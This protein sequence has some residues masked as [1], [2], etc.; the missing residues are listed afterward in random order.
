MSGAEKRVTDELS[1]RQKVEKYL[2]EHK[3]PE[4]FERL[5][6]LLIVAKPA[7]PKAYIINALTNDVSEAEAQV[8]LSDEDIKRMFEMLENPIEKG[9][10]T[11]NQMKSTLKALGIKE[12]D[13][14][15]YPTDLSDKDQIKID[16]FTEIIKANNQQL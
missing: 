9:Y 15:H 3:I 14:Q 13:N 5:L 8:L 1:D 2:S 12:A 6:A 4:M 16:Q 7:D 10:I 11:G